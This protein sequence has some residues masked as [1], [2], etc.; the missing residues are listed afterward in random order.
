MIIA[1]FILLKYQPWA[2]VRE[3]DK[4]IASTS[5]TGKQYAKK[6]RPNET[7]HSFV[8]R[9]VCIISPK[10]ESG[11]FKEECISN[12]SRNKSVWESCD[13]HHYWSQEDSD[14]RVGILAWNCLD[15]LSVASLEAMAAYR[16]RSAF[17]VFIPHTVDPSRSRWDNW[18]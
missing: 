8:V 17:I 6:R 9:S 10:P 7:S 16:V 2:T 18:F 12:F 4:N 14:S 11:E 1:P 15:H 3:R 5:W 13:D